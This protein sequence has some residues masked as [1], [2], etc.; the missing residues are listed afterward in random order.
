MI[1]QIGKL[2]SIKDDNG[3]F[4]LSAE[5]VSFLVNKHKNSVYESRKSDCKLDKLAIFSILQDL[6]EMQQPQEREIIGDK[7]G[8]LDGL[9]GL[10]KENIKYRIT[11]QKEKDV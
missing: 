1:S 8:V 2:L 11:I 7:E 5:E 9:N 3:Q 4:V 10:L 6:V